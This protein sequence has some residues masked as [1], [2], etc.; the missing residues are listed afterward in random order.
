MVIKMQRYFIKEKAINNSLVII[1]G[2]DYHHIKN[3]MRFKMGDLVIINTN[4]NKSYEASISSFTNDKVYLEIKKELPIKKNT[5]NLSIA[6]TLI[7]RDNFELVLQK[8]T[9]LG[10]KEIYPILTSRSIIKISDLS[11]KLSR[12]NS[13]VKEA[14]EQSE[15]SSLPVVHNLYK[16]DS[17]PFDEFDRVLIAY[18]REQ[19]NNLF[20]V[21]KDINLIH[22]E[23]VLLTGD[24]INEG[25]LEDFECLRNQTLAVKLL[26]KFEVPVYLVPGNHDLGGWDATPPSQG[27]ARREWW[28]FFGW[29]QR[30]IPPTKAEYLTHDYSFDYGNTHF[31]GLEAYDNYDRYMY[32]IYGDESFISS[33]ITWLKNDLAEAGDKTK[34]L[35]YHYD[36]KH[37]LNLSSDTGQS[38]LT[39]KQAVFRQAS[40]D[41][42]PFL[43]RFYCRLDS[44]RAL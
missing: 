2:K 36:F 41:T 43:L 12:Y 1:E 17:L 35:F 32:D 9:E 23:F 21:I 27:T 8:T 34:V 39:V 7:K 38:V 22:P 24:L 25:E 20:E 16:L 28:R 42:I 30:E 14:S 31:T 6:Q 29:R 4:Q 40:E 13:I 15:R 3:V 33:Q 18:A 26:E 44:G 11:K 5:I 37:E 19:K 10:I